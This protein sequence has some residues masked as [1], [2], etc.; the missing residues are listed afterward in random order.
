MLIRNGIAVSPGVV[1]GPAL[2]LGSEDFRIPNRFVSV[3]AVEVELK[4]F[5]KALE[6]VCDELTG[7]EKLA[8]EQLGSQYGAI[9]GAHLQMV[10]D[11]KLTG[12]IEGLVREKNHSPEFA[13]SRVLRRYARVFENLG[14]SYLRER[15]DDIYDLEKRILSHL[16][17][18]SREGLDKLTAP[19]LVLAHNLTPGETAGL[20]TRYVLG[21]ATEGGGRTSHTAILAGAIEIP[22]VV[23][24]GDFLSDVSGGET[25]IIDGN[26]GAVIIDP[27]EATLQKYRVSEQRAKS[28]AARLSSLKPMRAETKDGTRVQVFSNIEFPEEVGHCTERGADGIGLFRTEFLYLRSNRPPEEEEQYAAY[29]RVLKE[30]PESPVVI[31]TLDIGA[32]K[33]PSMVSKRV[34]RDHNPMLGLRSIR[35]SLRD[36]PMFKT[37]LRAILRAAVYGDVRIMF[38][39]VSS[40]LELRQARMILGD[41]IEDLEEEGIPFRG[42]VPV[43]M[44]VEVPSAAILASEFAK[45]VDFFSIG[46]NDLI[47]YTLACDR[48][49][50]QVSNLYRS[51]DPS[52]LRLIGMVLKAAGEHDRKVTVCGQM[53]SDPKF[54]PLLIGMGLRHLSATPYAIPKVKEVIR[55]ISI[56][57]AEQIAAHVSKLELARDVENYLLGELHRICPDLVL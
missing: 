34:S 25:V 45:E 35:L 38:P 26:H 36:L 54:V 19:V 22:A 16:L 2:V 13:A 27:D 37:Q 21:F 14:D 49:D 48:S 52:V 17:G 40:L 8:N 5:H 28:V 18:S 46:T 24:I 53:S 12:E 42:D 32:D 44:M 50:P 31:R 51:G 55:N 23:G 11:P 1:I 30:F 9:F 57:H 56:S 41:V 20:D 10:K 47:Q 33:V 7:N 15:A 43:G 3:D 39:L 6:A 4:R 29:I